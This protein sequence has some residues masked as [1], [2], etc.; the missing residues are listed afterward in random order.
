MSVKNNKEYQAVLKEIDELKA[1]NSSMENTMLEYLDDM[2]VKNKEIEEIKKDF[3]KLSKDMEMEKINLI[4]QNEERE[5][6][7]RNFNEEYEL[8]L[9]DIPEDI[10]REYED[11]KKNVSK[12][13]VVFV[14]DG[15]CSG[16][17]LSIPP[18]KY[19]ELQKFKAIELCTRCGRI[20]YYYELKENV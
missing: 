6:E 9:S 2:D 19:N 3:Q 7:L 20:I 15:I 16:C 14:K 18:Q 8:R 4:H 1:K 5:K 10:L 13:A 11:I 17:N 12:N